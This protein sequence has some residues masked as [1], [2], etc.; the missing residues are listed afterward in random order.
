MNIIPH[1]SK[2]TEGLTRSISSIEFLGNTS[3][4]PMTI[5]N[6][7][8]NSG[9]YYHSMEAVRVPHDVHIF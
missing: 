4:I 9:R 8:D 6:S 1:I 2:D 7:Y 5:V 3:T